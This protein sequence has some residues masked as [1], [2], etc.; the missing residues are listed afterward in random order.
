[1]HDARYFVVSGRVQGVCFRAATQDMARA[2]G[3]SGWVRNRDDGCVEGL[4]SGH[5][6][7]LEEFHQ[8]L[9]KGPSAARVERVMFE[10]ADSGEAPDT[11]FTIR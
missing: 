2:L 3:L 11:G 1:M 7:A 9:G 6:A 8:W 10:N 5:H 4:A